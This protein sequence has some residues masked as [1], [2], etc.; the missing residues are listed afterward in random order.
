MSRS[1]SF[2]SFSLTDIQ[3][4]EFHQQ[5]YLVIPK[6][7]NTNDVNIFI[8]TAKKELESPQKPYELEADLGYPEAP[9]KS[10]IGGSTVRRFLD[11]YNRK[12]LWQ[13]WASNP[14]VLQALGELFSTSRICLSMAHHNCLMT[15]APRYS[16]R[17]GWHQDFRYW[18]YEQ[19]DLISAWLALGEE[20]EINGAIHVVPKS[21][22]LEFKAE[23]FDDDMFFREDMSENEQLL[24]DE[25][26]I[27]LNP[28]DL[29]LFHCNLLHRAGK[30]QTDQ[31]KLAL[32]YT[33]RTVLNKPVPNT[34]SSLR[35]DPIFNLDKL[36]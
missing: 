23:Q 21:H 6:V 28:G 36:T 19:S 11:A 13:E 17:T 26:L 18:S 5:G 15:K 9:L 33:Y 8:N 14:S 24:L 1:F 20:N 27:T 7:L 3:K 29:L 34:R 31:T 4:E 22:L 12:T 30:N 2:E 32:V 25:K 16:S 10:G 35:L